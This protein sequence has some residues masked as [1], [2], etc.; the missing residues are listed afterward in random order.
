MYFLI[1]V[2]ILILFIVIGYFY[3]RYRIRRTLDSV[4]F[5]RMNLKD[6][7]EEAKIE[8]QEV[9]KSLA[10]MDRIYLRQI[11]KDFPNVHIV[12]L[13]RDAEK[14]LYQAFQ[15]V[16]KKDSHLLK[17]KIKDYADGMIQ[18]YSKDAQFSH[19]KIHN[20]VVSSYKKDR[21]L[22]VICFS[23]SFEYY[24]KCGSKDNKTQDRVRL[25]YV[26]VID[27]KEVPEDSMAIGI[28]CPNCG[29]PITSLGDKSCSYCGTQVLELKKVFTCNDI[30]RY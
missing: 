15:A 6:I 7:I 9:P 28:H 4:G 30:V 27:E 14:V 22:A 24:V 17:G 26:Y 2:V 29:S 21:A 5:S 10:S 8:D 11:T 12:E 20:T 16:L 13:K 23:I 19:F 18:D 25:E 3:I 1:G